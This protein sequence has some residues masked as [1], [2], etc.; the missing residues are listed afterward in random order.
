[1]RW[2]TRDSQDGKEYPQL[3]DTGCDREIVGWDY[4]RK[5]RIPAKAIKM[6]VVLEYMDGQASKPCTHAVWRK[7]DFP[8]TNGTRTYKIKY[9][10]ADIPEGFVLGLHWLSYADPILNLSARTFTWRIKEE[11]AAPSAAPSVQEVMHV[12]KARQQIIQGAI[13]ANEPPEWVK[14][15][16]MDVLTPRTSGLPPHRPGWDFK[17]EL[18]PGFKPRKA[19]ARRYSPQERVMFEDLERMEVAAGRW[20]LSFSDQAVPLL[21]AAKAGGEKRPCTDYRYINPWIKDD[22]FPIPNMRDLLSR[23]NG[24]KHYF[25]LDIPKAY[26]ELRCADKETEDLL[27]FVCNDKLYAPTVM[28]FG[29]KTSVSWFQR[30][31]THVLTKPLSDYGSNMIVYLDNI[32]GGFDT[33]DQH[34]QCLRLVLKALREL[35]LMLQPK[36]CEWG[37]S[38]VQVCGFLLSAEGIRIDPEKLRAVREWK[39]PP[40]HLSESLKKT[41]VREFHGFCNFFRDMISKFSEI[42]EPLTRVMGPKA[43]WQW[44]IEQRTAWKML[45]LA[46][47]GAPVLAAFEWGIPVEV[48]ADGANK[49]I[50][51]MVG[52]RYENGTVKPIGYYSKKLSPAEQNYPTH[53]KELLAIRKTFEHFRPWL[54]GSKEPIKV[55]S[56]HQA[57]TK[58]LTKN[59]LGN[60]RVARWA[61]Y[62]SEF[63]FVIHHLPGKDNSAA[64]ALSRQN[65]DGTPTGG[66]G[67][68]LQPHNFA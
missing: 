39:E 42:T 59:D 65:E 7:F 2:V 47:C 37:K 49:G 48:W 55:W 36:K 57:L 22:A 40:A 68:V 46:C 56:D 11:V 28:Q 64:D 60:Q 51:S 26:W 43:E 53:D 27:A 52:H 66:G 13:Q 6:P 32:A 8:G 4:I 1:M 50:G 5:H 10:V 29:C 24:K 35:G 61:E 30:F 34:D 45:K 41:R 18:K 3:V 9:L 15:E 17:I 44:G 16:F 14:A 19:P 20:R 12:R 31:I 58:F 38:E 21:W 33:M 23:L 63:S 62:L 67:A 25:S 54:H